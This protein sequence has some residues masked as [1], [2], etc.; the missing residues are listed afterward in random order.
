MM[1]IAAKPLCS[2]A[3]SHRRLAKSSKSTKSA[4]ATMD[5][6]VATVEGVGGANDALIGTTTL[7]YNP[8]EV[9]IFFYMNIVNAAQIIVSFVFA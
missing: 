3:S 5:S 1:A 9:F 7:M 2:S 4:K 8:G 6:H